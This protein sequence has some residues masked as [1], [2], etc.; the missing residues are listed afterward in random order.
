MLACQ[1][2]IEAEQGRAHGVLKPKTP[3][4]IIGSTPH[5]SREA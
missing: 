5:N 3:D 1:E 4:K 2:E